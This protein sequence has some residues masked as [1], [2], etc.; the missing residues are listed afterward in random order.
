[1]SDANEK[2]PVDIPVILPKPD[3]EN[4]EWFTRSSEPDTTK[5]IRGE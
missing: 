2:E 4:S 1:M 3:K 5:I